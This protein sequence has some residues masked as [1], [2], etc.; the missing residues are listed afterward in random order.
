MSLYDRE[1][2]MT[3]QDPTRPSS[4]RR[5]S[6]IVAVLLT[7]SATVSGWW[8]TPVEAAGKPI[9]VFDIDGTLT[10]DVLSSTAHVGAAKA[11]NL[12]V[13]K[14]YNVVYVTARPKSLFEQS[15]REWLAK[16]GFPNRPLYM[17]SSLLIADADVE[18]YKTTTLKQLEATSGQV[19]YAYGDSTT[20]FKA[21][22]NVGTPKS[23]VF[24]LKRAWSWS[25]QPGVW[26]ACL[27]DYVQH[28]TTFIQ[29]RPSV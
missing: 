9:V 10:N 8:A 19:T 1:K 11:V 21:Y 3:R 13:P 28:T 22:A 4:V 20:D 2:H 17:A 12:Y 23:S 5:R 15:T 25:C 26:A 7:L 24:A 29:T 16:N 27:K 14:G 6:F 18:A